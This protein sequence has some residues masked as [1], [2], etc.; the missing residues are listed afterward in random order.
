M[1][2]PYD[3]PKI[4]IAVVV[5]NAGYGASAAAPIASLMAEKYLTRGIT[6]NWTRNFWLKKLVEEVRSAPLEGEE[7]APAPPPTPAPTTRTDGDIAEA[8]E[9]PASAESEAASESSEQ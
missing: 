2:A 6:D 1:F 8:T 7:E 9:P 3:D 4:A 5:E